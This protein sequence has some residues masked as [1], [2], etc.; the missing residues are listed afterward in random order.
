MS[1]F[2]INDFFTLNGKVALVTGGNKAHFHVTRRI[3]KLTYHAGS[4]GLGLHAATAFLLSGAKTIFI[5]AR[6]FNGEQG[7]GQAV[8]RLNALAKTES[9]PGRA[10]GIA[11]NVTDVKDIERLVKEVQ[12]HEGKLNILVANAG[13]TWGGPFE[14][15]PDWA[16]QKVLD[17]NVRGVFNLIRLFTPMLATSGS[18]SD[19][20]RVIIMSSVAGTSVPHVGDNGT[21]MYSASKAAA[22]HLARNLALELGPRNITTNTVAPGF[23]KS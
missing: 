20:S 5:T 10:I 19:P 3:R 17:V 11:S 7:I 14:P 15:T 18:A 6:K 9:L 23:C 12:K 4:R 21:I 16:S 13:A 8:D 22:H 2:N 1:D